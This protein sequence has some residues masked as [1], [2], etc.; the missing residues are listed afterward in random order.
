MVEGTVKF[1]DRKKHFGFISQDG[2]AD[3]FVHQSGLGQGVQI[4]EGD[5]VT[6]DIVEGDRGAKAENVEKME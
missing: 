3:I 2:G 4:D 5:R 1:F 6:F